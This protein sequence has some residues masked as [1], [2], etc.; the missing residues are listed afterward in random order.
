MVKDTKGRFPN[1]PL[2]GD[3]WGWSF[4]NADDRA[5][6]VSTDYRA[7]CLGCHEPA[8]STDLVYDYAYPVLNP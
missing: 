3:G 8:R 1:N 4:F 5:R 6:T 2:W 7:D